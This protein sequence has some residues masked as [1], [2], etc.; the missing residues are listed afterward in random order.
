M[1][2]PY[3]KS[4]SR[5]TGKSES[6]LEKLWSKA[7]EITSD[8][9][10]KKESEFGE[11]EYSYTVGIIKNMLGL[12]EEVLNPA[13]FLESEMNAREYIETITSSAFPSLDKD[14]NPPDKEDDE[15]KKKKDPIIITKE[16][17]KKEIEPIIV[18]DVSD[19]D[20][21]SALDEML[22]KIK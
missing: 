6:E 12:K 2:S 5:E 1:P 20:W 18:E 15:D 19:D 3:I 22:N 11:K 10:N 16:A 14:L 7:K 21:G 9:F 17:Q 8:T 13:K 4:L